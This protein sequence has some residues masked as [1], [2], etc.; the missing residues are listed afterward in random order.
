M[1]GTFNSYEYK[2]LAS[3]EL[4]RYICRFDVSKRCCFVIRKIRNV[5]DLAML[6]RAFGNRSELLFYHV[7]IYT[8]T[9]RSNLSSLRITIPYLLD[10]F[11]T[12]SRIFTSTYGVLGAN[13]RLKFRLL[14]LH[15]LTFLS[16]LLDRN[17]LRNL[18]QLC[19]FIKIR[20]IRI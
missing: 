15:G 4:Y 9:R 3:T 14:A 18:L 1:R 11:L 10:N 17:F 16:Q 6:L 8:V 13:S 2:S 19:R 5:Y 20:R 12:D 7:D